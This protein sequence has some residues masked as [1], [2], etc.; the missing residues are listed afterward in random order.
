M[1]E[2]TYMELTPEK[3]AARKK[4]TATEAL[5]VNDFL[6]A[7]RALPKSICIEVEDAFDG[8]PHL[9]VSKRITK[10]CAQQVATLRKASLVF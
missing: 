6:K 3:I 5:L 4:L 7:A 10:G 8:G 2:L 1:S 9:R